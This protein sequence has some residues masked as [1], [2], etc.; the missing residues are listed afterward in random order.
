MSAGHD[1]ERP[2]LQPKILDTF[3]VSLGEGHHPNWGDLGI[4]NL[5]EGSSPS[6]CISGQLHGGPNQM[7]R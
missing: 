4:A 3:S 7:K 1:G 5:G 6:K 2:Q